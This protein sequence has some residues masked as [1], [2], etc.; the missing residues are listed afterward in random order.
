M[1]TNRRLIKGKAGILADA[2][3]RVSKK[4]PTGK[5]QKIEHRGKNVSFP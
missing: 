5:M 3:S 1:S 4:P 2:C